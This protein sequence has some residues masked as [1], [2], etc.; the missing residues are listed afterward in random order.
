MNESGDLPADDPLFA[1]LESFAVAGSD[2]ESQ[3]VARLAALEDHAT[4]RA[5]VAAL[6]ADVAALRGDIADIK[7]ILLARGDAVPTVP[8][9]AAIDRTRGSQLL[10]YAPRDAAPNLLG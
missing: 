8:R 7:R 4:L 1:L 6:R 10:P 3:T 9:I 2:I 5:D